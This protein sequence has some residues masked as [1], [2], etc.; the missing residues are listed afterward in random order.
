MMWIYANQA[1]IR[2]QTCSHFEQSFQQNNS[3][4]IY[5]QKKSNSLTNTWVLNK[6]T[7]KKDAVC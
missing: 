1:Q 6:R 5:H 2:C 4:P 3:S 7:H